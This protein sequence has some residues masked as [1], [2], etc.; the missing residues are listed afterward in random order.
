MRDCVRT[1]GERIRLGTTTK[2]LN[3]FGYKNAIHE[4]PCDYRHRRST[5]SVVPTRN[6]LWTP[7]SILIILHTD[8]TA[9][10]VCTLPQYEKVGLVSC[11][12]HE[13]IIVLKQIAYEVKLQTER[14]LNNFYSGLINMFLLLFLLVKSNVSD[15][16]KILD[17]FNDMIFVQFIKH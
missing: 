8:D 9:R 15:S 16:L 6:L 4:F 3:S 1:H 2:C 14:Y 5:F 7:R 10:N 13:T 12:E 17:L 11:S